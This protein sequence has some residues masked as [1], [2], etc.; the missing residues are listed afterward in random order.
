[1]K[2]EYRH[3]PMGDIKVLN[4]LGAAG[5]RFVGKYYDA[6]IDCEIGLFEKATSPTMG[7][8]L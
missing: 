1:M 3:A 7:V 8:F 6:S 2:Y 4:E 5:F